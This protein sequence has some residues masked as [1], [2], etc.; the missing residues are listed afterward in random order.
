MLSI[1]QKGFLTLVRSAML[2]KPETLPEAFSMEKT[3]HLIEKQHM[4]SIALEG[5]ILCGISPDSP[6]IK[7][8][9]EKSCALYSISSCQMTEVKKLCVEFDENQIDYLPLKGINLK[10]LYP[11]PHMREMSDADILIRVAQYDKIVP[12]LKKNGFVRGQ[13]SDHELQWDKPALYLELHKRLV[14][15]N[16]RLFSKYFQNIWSRAI[17]VSDA[18]SLYTLSEEDELIFYVVHFAKHYRDGGIGAKHLI[19]LWLFMRTHPKLRTDYVISEL[20][21][22]SLDVFFRNL[23]TTMQVWFGNE[24]PTATTE[25]ITEVILGGGAYG[26]WEMQYIAS[27]ARY[28]NAFGSVERG[29]KQR[30]K[31]LFFPPVDAMCRLYPIL[32]KAPVLLPIFWVYRWIH[33]LL[34]KGKTVKT[35]YA[36]ARS[37]TP[38]VI[39]DYQKKLASVG[40]SFDKKE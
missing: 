1:Q 34:F 15:T 24:A 13:E 4:T 7:S 38:Q 31:Y 35:R 30:I 8:L 12:I 29:R 5:A 36:E 25:T 3:M 39:E 21:K 26:S 14:P 18:K 10:M 22:L 11:E 32:K 40:L 20:E 9:V 27:A 17:R 37:V 33:A 23:C 2:H 19:D 16:N 28:S 6:E